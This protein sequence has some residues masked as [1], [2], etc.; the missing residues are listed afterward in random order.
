MPGPTMGLPLPGRVWRKR[1]AF[2]FSLAPLQLNPEPRLRVSS[3]LSSPEQPT[4]QAPAWA[5][6]RRP[7]PGGALTP[8]TLPSCLGGGRG[9]WTPMWTVRSAQC[10]AAEKGVSP[11][12]EGLGGA[13]EA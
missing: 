10:D 6:W 12:G 8:P 11:V 2:G 9:F 1:P 4:P 3:S 7:E 5:P 13:A